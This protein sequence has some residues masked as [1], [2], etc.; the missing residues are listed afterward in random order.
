MKSSKALFSLVERRNVLKT[1]AAG[2]AFSIPGWVLGKGA[3]W[4][5]EDLPLTPQQIEGPFYP[6]K[7]I[8]QQLYSDTDLSR[9]LGD[10]EMAKGQ[11]CF[12]E[13]V[14]SDRKGR[15][16]KGAVV[17]VWQAC[18]SGRYNHS[19]DDRNPG[20]LDNNF[21]F[22]GRAITGDDGKYGFTSIVP[23]KY[24]GRTAR[25]IHFRVDADG[26]RRCTT[27]SYFSDFGEDNM[28]DGIYRSLGRAERE[29]VTVEFDK[30]TKKEKARSEKEGDEKAD[31]KNRDTKAKQKNAKSVTKATNLWKGKF[32][33][34]M[35]R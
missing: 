1:L 4:V 26:Y 13:G 32:N 12:V 22:W 28:R 35:G 17:E 3:I 19:R 11:P 2:A 27:Q 33:I 6:E 23:G 34:V 15:P 25:H 16:I 18:A 21:Q 5:P 10:H 31:S 7:S 9:K 29:L 24:P 14:V 8:E 20:L 30:P